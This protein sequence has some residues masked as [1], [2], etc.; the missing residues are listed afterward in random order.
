MKNLK[1]NATKFLAITSLITLALPALADWKRVGPYGGNDLYPTATGCTLGGWT[2]IQVKLKTAPDPK[3][4]D[5]N[6]TQRKA[7]NLGTDAGTDK[8]YC[9]NKDLH[10]KSASNGCGAGWIKVWINS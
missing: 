2:C 5:T 10:I 6:S 4:V 8:V 3:E 7:A 1:K 9:Q